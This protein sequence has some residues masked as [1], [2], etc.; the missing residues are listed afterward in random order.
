MPVNVHITADFNAWRDAARS[1]LNDNIPPGDVVWSDDRSAD[2]LPMLA[3]YTPRPH[4]DAQQTRALRVSRVFIDT[5]R[6]VACHRDPVRWSLLYRTLWRL[7]HG[8]PALLNI[9]SDDDTHALA[10]MQKAVRR[11]RH[12]M[13]AFVRFKQVADNEY[14]AWYRPDHYTLRLAAAHFQ[15]R[16]HVMRWFILTPDDSVRWDGFTLT[17]GP[18]APRDAAP[19]DDEMEKLW[20]TYYA[21]I[22]NPARIKIR[23][24]KNEMPT[25]FW[26]EL[27]EAHIIPDLLQQAPARVQKMIEQSSRLAAD[28]QPLNTVPVTDDLQVLSS[29]AC[30]CRMCPLYEHATQTVFG[31]GPV[32]AKIMLVGE[33]PG[34]TEDI[35]GQPFIGP[36]GQLLDEILT[37]LGIQRQVL[38]VTNAVKHFKFEQRGTRRIHVRPNA[39]EI[40]ACRP[41]VQR[42]VS[43]VRPLV[44][45]LLG[46]TACQSLVGPQFKLTRDRGK[47]F[48]TQWCNQT[49]AT[50]HPS[51]LLRVPDASLRATM[52]AAFTGDLQTAYAAA[53][54]TK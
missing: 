38:Y 20:L 19:T 16:F 47:L 13:H 6:Y 9:A 46:A 5:A 34:D 39:K 28:Q 45:V 41:W 21:H 18:G 12:K 37:E 40:A 23:A 3:T 49:I 10:M 25:R 31:A 54:Q 7:T 29:A 30:A 26:K 15:N 52:R 22:F 2:L 27:P 44:L 32:D 35:A 48:Q 4:D 17:F 36:A 33:Q 24:M 43:V 8:E 42:E 50:Y 1:L 51:A 14:M 53:S 11:D